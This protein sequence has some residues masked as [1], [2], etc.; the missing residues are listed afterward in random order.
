MGGGKI[1]PFF[2]LNRPE[3]LAEAEGLLGGEAA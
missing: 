2:N 3:E 1:D